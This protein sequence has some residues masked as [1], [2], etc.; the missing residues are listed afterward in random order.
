MEMTSTAGGAR[1]N[2]VGIDYHRRL[3]RPYP[4]YAYYSLSNMK[5]PLSLKETQE[6]VETHFKSFPDYRWKIEELYAVK[7]RI[8]VRISISGT[9]TE[10][11]GGI[12]PTG[13]K[14]ESSAIFIVRMEGGKV[15]EQ[16]KEVSASQVMQQPGMEL[17]PKEEER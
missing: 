5:N 8:I 2:H 15:V 17:R 7:D 11:Y 4:D 16:R 10:E 9:F 12:T 14:I 1:M 6:K 3:D 13:E